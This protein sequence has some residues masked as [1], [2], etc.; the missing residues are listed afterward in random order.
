M[1]M[2]KISDSLKV[3]LQAREWNQRELAQAL[4]YDEGVLSQ[5]LS[6]EAEPSKQLMRKLMDLTGFDFG[7]GSLFIY[8]K[9][10]NPKDV[11]EES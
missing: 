8:D 1:G 5:V 10:A 4:N 2:I 7:K 6:G 11:K 3:W 9:N